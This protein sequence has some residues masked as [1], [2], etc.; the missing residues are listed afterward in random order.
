MSESLTLDVGGMTCDGCSNRVKDA[1]E[2]IPGVD[3]ADVSHQS[4]MPLL[5]IKKYPERL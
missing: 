3:F 4:G 1:L 5:N 2:S